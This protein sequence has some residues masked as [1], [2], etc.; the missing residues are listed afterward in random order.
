MPHASD[1]PDMSSDFDDSDLDCSA[2]SEDN[3]QSQM[4]VAPPVPEL[5]GAIMTEYRP[6]I[7]IYTV[8]SAERATDRPSAS[9]CCDLFRPLCP[10]REDEGDQ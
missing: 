9:Q 6:F 4:G 3:F 7:E 10:R 5:G 1:L 2:E 8:C